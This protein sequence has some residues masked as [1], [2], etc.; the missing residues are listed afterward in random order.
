MKNCSFNL[1]NK[2]VLPCNKYNMLPL[3]R[4]Q[5]DRL[6]VF[7]ELLSDYAEFQHADSADMYMY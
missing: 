2:L 1:R 3:D 5:L 4:F 7:N 6:S